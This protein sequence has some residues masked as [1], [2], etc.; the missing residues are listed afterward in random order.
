MQT[1]TAAFVN[2]L[3]YGSKLPMGNPS[4]AA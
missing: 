1:S 3:S 2:M 4:T